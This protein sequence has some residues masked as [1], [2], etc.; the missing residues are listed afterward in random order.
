MVSIV[1]PA[2]NSSK[3]L[4]YTLP[5]ILVQ[6]RSLISDVIV[7]DSSDD[8]L[9][10]GVISEFEPQGI[11][12]INS[13]TRVMPA[14]QRNIGARASSGKILLFLD[15]DVIL[16]PD[17]V[18]KI[19]GFHREGKTAGFGSVTIPP[20]QARIV[21]VIAQY[22][23]Q[24]NEY[25]PGGK[26]RRKPFVL[27]CSNYV[28]REV[29]D[30]VGG[31]PEIRAAEDVLYGFKL[32]EV[33]PIWFLPSASV[34][35]IFREDWQGFF[36]NQELLGKYVARY[37]KENSGGLAFKGPMPILLSP[38]FFLVKWLRIS[39]RIIGSGPRHA[40]LSLSVAPAFF[41]G[42]AHWVRGF[43]REA[44]APGPANGRKEKE[45]T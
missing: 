15:S 11:R 26:P 36:N 31:Y 5:S 13:G 18:A 17:Y 7:V 22:Y 21:P 14:V 10:A 20:F 19:V 38:A 32:S 37:R 29:F 35:H 28:E 42:L 40:L 3:T 34:A 24:L 30:K 25:L 16:E 43:V 27:G 33:C 41:M 23:L 9:M 2:F 6:D 39:P 8:G 1:I 45:H 44:M 4:K 12:F